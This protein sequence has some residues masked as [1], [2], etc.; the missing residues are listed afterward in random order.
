MFPNPTRRKYFNLCIIF[1][2]A[3]LSAY[4]FVYLC[5][6]GCGQYQPASVGINH[7]EQYDWAP[8]GFY[9]P[10][11]P[12][13]GSLAAIRD[14]STNFG[15]WNCFAIRIFYPLYELDRFFIHKSKY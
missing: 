11:H 7:V 4:G 12:W 15:G 9:D 8:L 14:K 1:A 3:L 13:K 10:G 5:L 6:S 2:C